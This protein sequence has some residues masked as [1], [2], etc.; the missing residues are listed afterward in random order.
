MVKEHVEWENVVEERKGKHRTEEHGNRLS[1]CAIESEI[2]PYTC[3][4]I[5]DI[6]L[7]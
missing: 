1:Y 6:L 4:E 5:R 2:V 7:L 3:E